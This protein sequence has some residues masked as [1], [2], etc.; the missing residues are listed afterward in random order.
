MAILDRYIARLYL[1]NIVAILVALMSFVVA[2]DV[3][4]NLPALMG[5]GRAI[6]GDNAPA[7]ELAL[8]VLRVVAGLWGPRLLQ[9]FSYLAGVV[10][11][12]A[13][14]FTCVNLVR[15]RECVAVLASGLSLH[16]LFVPFLAVALLVTAA[17]AV[18]Q[19]LLI[20]RVAHRLLRN[21][22]NAATSAGANLRV[23][24]LTDSANRLWYAVRYD[25]GDQ[26]LEDLAVWERDPEGGVTSRITADAARWT[27]AEWMLEH[28]VAENLA[29]DR[30]P[31][32]RIATDL[33]P[34]A[35]LVN[36]FKGFGQNLS[37][38]QISAALN[39]PV[40]VSDRTRRELNTIRYGRVGIMACNLL[41]LCI[42]LPFFLMRE[43]RGML[44]QTIKAAPVAAVALIG[45][46]VAVAAPPPGL[47]VWVG[48]MIP[49]LVLIP[50]AIATTSGLRT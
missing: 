14:G 27:G 29:G 10:C 17:Q 45:A 15:R 13:M 41:T 26:R 42:V 5:A 22:E 43:P 2:V 36:R 31:I 7:H 12:A 37:W 33:D 50:I 4:V 16:R 39:Q 25:S 47:P 9:L 46:V 6:A 48:A 28:G 24:L 18:D 49:A 8:A 35:I 38:R 23:P 21:Y 3:V 32:D 34:T 11:I 20:P 19:E 1:T 30:A 44:R 40:P